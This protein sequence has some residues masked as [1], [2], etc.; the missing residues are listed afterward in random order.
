MPNATLE[1]SQNGKR[2]VKTSLVALGSISAIVSLFI[3]LGGFIVGYIT[4]KADMGSV[5]QQL[6]DL[7]ADNK[8]LLDRQNIMAQTLVDDRQA[9]TNRLTSLEAEAKYISQ[10]VAELKLANVPKR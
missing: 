9:I 7:R 3:F 6:H 10:G 8:A 5:T 4:F 2:W 1:V